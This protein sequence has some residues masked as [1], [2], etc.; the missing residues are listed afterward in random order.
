MDYKAALQV[1]AL[2]VFLAVAYVSF[3]VLVGLFVSY[4]LYLVLET[5]S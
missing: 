4:V 1:A 5:K 2:I 3:W